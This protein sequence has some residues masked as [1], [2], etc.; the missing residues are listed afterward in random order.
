MTAGH[1]GHGASDHI[2][3]TSELRVIHIS[4][5]PLAAVARSPRSRLFF[6][7]LGCFIPP[8]PP[9]FATL[10]LSAW[11]QFLPSFSVTHR[12]GVW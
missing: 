9:V 11:P 10:G 2:M 1:W 7:S 6:A 12:P 5:R 4:L 8:H 3:D